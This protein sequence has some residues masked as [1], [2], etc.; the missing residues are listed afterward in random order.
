MNSWRPYPLLRLVIPFAAGILSSIFVLNPF[1]GA[2]APVIVLFALTA[3]LVA[4]PIFVKSYGLRWI[5]GLL[6]NA[7]LLTAGIEI[8]SLHKPSGDPDFIGNHPDGFF[9]ATVDEPPS[10][11]ASG[12]RAILKIRFRHGESGWE[13]TKGSVLGYLKTRPGHRP[14]QFGDYLILHARFYKITDNSNPNTFN[15]PQYLA[16]K[17][18]L[19]RVYAETY[20]WTPVNICPEGFIRKTAF[21]VRDR[22]LEVLRENHVEGKEFAVA[23][24]LLLGYVDDLDSELRKDY[25]ATGAMHILSVSGMHVGIIYLFLEF[26]LG[27]LNKSRAGRFFKAFLLL[28]FIWFYAT[29]TGLSPCVLRS[30]AM[31]S[32]PI[33]GKA[34]N[35][36]PNMYNIIAASMIMILAIDPFLIMDVGFQLSYLAVTGIILLYKPIYDWYVTSAWLPDKIWS[37][38]AVSIAAQISTLPITLYTFHQF[39]N[40]FM[41]TNIFV[42]PLSSLI[43]YVGILALVVGQVP[44][45]CLFTAKILVFLVWLLNTVIHSIEELPYSVIRGIFISMPEM[46]LLYAFI[47]AVFVFL[48]S[49]RIL[50]LYFTLLTAIVLN[51]LNLTF[52][53]DRLKSSRLMIFNVNREAL[54]MFSHQDRAILLYHGT[55]R[56]A[57]IINR[58]NLDPAMAAMEAYGIMHYRH[59]WLKTADRPLEIAKSFV[60]VMFTGDFAEF[61]GCRIALLDKAIPR[62][63]NG[64]ID[65]DLLIITGNPGIKVANVLKVFNPSQIII[66]ATNSRFKIRQ[67]MKDASGHGI[68]CHAVTESGAYVK[69]F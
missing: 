21:E 47:A 2:W 34:L 46:L 6:F 8:T 20:D 13:R 30:A 25:A 63:F 50:F 17:G 42:V 58:P 1:D 62:G 18:I 12:I 26:L 35:R 66:D 9:L 52:K 19:H 29:L 37:I 54:L 31:L 11:N 24:A 40:Y 28:V 48:T 7:F 57:G 32:L 14:V 16:N 27:F 45:V 15:C 22:L 59:F 23:A 64:H 51:M 68:K 36:S 5:S 41:L 44:I 67:W 49:R 69:V 53:I 43:I 33:L 56:S 60:P 10:V 65:A 61:H 3:G 4:L 55:T 39:P 38:L